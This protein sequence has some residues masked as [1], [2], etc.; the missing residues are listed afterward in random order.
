MTRGEGLR[1][2]K[3]QQTRRRIR[4]AAIELFASRGFD[5]VPVAEIA[6]AADV[7]AATVFNYFPTK[8]DLVYGGM[9]AFEDSLL[10]AVRSRPTGTTASEAFRDFVLQRRG[11]LADPDPAAMAHLATVAKV[12]AG[13]PALQAREHRIVDQTTQA[14]AEI[15]AEER[16][17]PAG[18]VRPWVIANALIGVNRAI[19]RTIQ[20]D[21][22]AGRGADATT[23]HALA[24]GRRA[25]Q[26]VH[27]GLS[28][29]RG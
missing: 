5:A 21:A 8:E 23:R 1:E 19:T 24:E 27:H 20:A 28:D 10:Q 4:Q 9:E 11:A 3:K 14:L 26:A 18:D 17:A 13:S 2:R 12:I 6:Q 15:I 25:F 16:H 7:S 22:I 29:E